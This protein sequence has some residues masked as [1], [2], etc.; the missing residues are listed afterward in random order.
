MAMVQ[1]SA[2]FLRKSTFFSLLGML[3]FFLAGCDRTKPPPKAPPPPTVT[4]A[5]PVL[6]EVQS[7]RDYTGFLDPIESVNIRARVKGFLNKVEFKEGADVDVGS[8][9][10]TIDPREYQANLARSKADLAK[11]EAELSRAKSD[12]SRAY[13]GRQTSAISE[14]DYLQRVA[15]R[16]AAQAMVSQSKAAIDI[17]NL[18]LS[19]TKITSPIKGRVS[20]TLI[21]EGNLVGYN[22]ATLLTT[23]VRLDSLYVY[24][25]VPERDMVEYDRQA[26]LKGYPTATENKIPIV[27]GLP[28]EEGYS[29][30]GYIDFREN[31]VD[32]G[33][34]TIRLR[35]VIQNPYKVL[36]PGL[37]ARIRFPQG[38][39]VQQFVIPEA[40]LMTDQRGRYVYVVD[41]ENKVSTRT[42]K[43]GV[44][45]GTM[46]ST[47]E[48]LKAEDWVI[49]NGIQRARPGA[50]I[51]PEKQELKAPTPD[52]TLPLRQALN[53]NNDS[54][55][56]V[57]PKKDPK[58]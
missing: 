43:I 36:L 54:K 49:V 52:L 11:A 56:P 58:K 46:M 8:P 7:F 38:E 1:S 33:T 27:V 35:G 20:R 9:L 12:E 45:I 6:A 28:T 57:E 2:T 53:P 21:T 13:R 23:I 50:I 22:E 31:R 55:L 17:A 51:T 24:F 47:E 41:A 32:I 16:E 18:D 25:D 29:H 42:V 37:Y 48:G 19:F 15:A 5:K 14:E 4:V 44:P 34:G 26:R 30:S 40:A 10:Y 39:P 3:F